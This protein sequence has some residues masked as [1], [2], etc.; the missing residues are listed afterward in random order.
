VK[1]G[2]I[3]GIGGPTLLARAVG[4][5]M[6]LELLTTGRPIGAEEALAKGLVNHVYPSD[7][8]LDEAMALARQIAANAPLAVKAA[9]R[10]VRGGQHLASAEAMALELEEYGRLFVTADRREG[11]AAFNAKRSPAFRGE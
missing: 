8:L 3:P 4:P 11:V 10:A 7:R 1:L 2:F 5:R 6:A 9:K